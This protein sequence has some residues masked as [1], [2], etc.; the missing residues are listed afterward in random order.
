MFKLRRKI[1]N[2]FKQIK[3]YFGNLKERYYEKHYRQY[4]AKCANKLENQLIPNFSFKGFNYILEKL[5]FSVK[6]ELIIFIHNYDSIFDI[7]QY[8]LLKIIV[9]RIESNSGKVKIYT[10]YRKEG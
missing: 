7:N 4:I 5:L 2:I 6:H 9:E 10:F 3:R 8:K 1:K